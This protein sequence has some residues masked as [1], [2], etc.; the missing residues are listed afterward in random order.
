[1]M[2]TEDRITA[3]SLVEESPGHARFRM[4]DGMR[5]GAPTLR[6]RNLE[7][8]LSFYETNLGLKTNRNYQDS[9]DSLRTLELG[10]KT[11][12]NDPETIL[13]LK[14]DP[15]A[16]TTAHDFAGLY[17]YAVLVPDRKSLA[18]TYL[19]IQGSG[20]S[21]DGFADHTFS[22]SL[23]LHDVERNGIEIYADR[24]RNTWGAI[25]VAMRKG[26]A[27]GLVS[28]NKPLDLDSLLMEL[29]RDEKNGQFPFPRGTR[30]GHVHLRITDLERSVK[31]YHEKLGL[32]I[33]ANLPEMGIAFLSVGGYHHQIGLNTWHSLGG[34]PHKDGQ[35][36]LENITVRVP[37]AGVLD[38]LA[39]EF[40]DA[41][42]KDGRLLIPDPDGIRIL[43]EAE[44]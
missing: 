2:S 4:H 21:Y 39:I 8:V 1:M 22:E 13:V 33:T 9:S 40:P 14:H 28:L 41:H 35:A 43:I 29:S 11:N 42:V 25:M 36:G 6:V 30:I 5:L 10:F 18:S 12:P 15:K 20:A 27:R 38:A 16:A 31:F 24:P 32:D 3:S 7:K 17:H 34:T 26:D 44:R 23:Y 37:D 19:A